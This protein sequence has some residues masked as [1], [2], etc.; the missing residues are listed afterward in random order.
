MTDQ[1]LA[2]LEGKAVSEQGTGEVS[3]LA[4]VYNN[5]DL[6]DD[7]LAPGALSKT[8]GDWSRAR[9]RVPLIDWHGDSLNR[10]IGSV[11]ELKSIAEGLWFRARFAATEAAQQ[12]RQLAR[13]GHL[14]GVSIGYLPI[15]QSFKTIGGRRVRILHEVRLLEISLTPVP[16]NP[17]AQLASVKSVGY[18]AGGYDDTAEELERLEAWAARAELE[19]ARERAADFAMAPSSTYQLLA[20]VKSKLEMETLEAELT[21]WA[22][23]PEVRAGMASDPVAENAAHVG[24]QRDRANRESYSL[25]GW[26]ASQAVTPS[27]CGGRCRMCRVGAPSACQYR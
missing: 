14:S 23:S 4:A 25:A 7:Q 21:A 15:R 19:T 2:R 5:V 26:M 13:E 22:N 18:D 10:L 12:A 3:G 27:P 16:A 24:A 17:E 1:L 20:N 11:V 6:Q 8:V 9:S